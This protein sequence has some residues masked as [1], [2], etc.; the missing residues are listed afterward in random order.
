MKFEIVKIDSDATGKSIG[1]IYDF[2][3]SADFDAFESD[4]KKMHNPFYVSCKV[5]L[6]DIAAVHMLERAGFNFIETQIKLSARLKK[7]YPALPENYVFKLAENS[8]E[9]DEAAKIAAT[10]FTDDR[11]TIDPEIPSEL[12]AQRYIKYVEESYKAENQAL[13]VLKKR[14][15][16]EVVAFKTHLYT[17]PD[18]ALLL[19]GGV[20]NE[21]KEMGIG[22]MN[23]YAELNFL[24]GI[25]VKR[26]YTN[27]SARNHAIMNLE[28]AAFG[29]KV[30]D[31]FAVT[32]KLYL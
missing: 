8:D 3:K 30:I 24:A 29:Y 5:S 14:E 10:T 20:K 25:G 7:I 1:A 22:I 9:V 23:N 17:A 6:Q 19:L 26:L 32:R 21:Y 27:V 28:I 11:F 18:E 4:Y 13:F 31:T 16:G 15:D 12:A 2:D